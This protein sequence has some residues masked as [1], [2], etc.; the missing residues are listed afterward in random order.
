VSGRTDHTQTS[1][2]RPQGRLSRQEAGRAVSMAMCR[3]DKRRTRSVEGRST[4]FF[5]AWP[6]S[7][8]ASAPT[9]SVAG[10][11]SRSGW[12][13]CFSSLRGCGLLCSRADGCYWFGT[14]SVDRASDLARGTSAIEN[15]PPVA[16]LVDARQSGSR[17]AQRRH[18]S[19]EAREPTQ[20][21]ADSISPIVTRSVGWCWSGC[22]LACRRVGIAAH[23]RR[24][25]SRSRPGCERS[26]LIDAP[27]T[28]AR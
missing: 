24:S 8:L 5:T 15:R 17:H 4:G 14:P 13:P 12:W 18:G 22:S 16:L 9:L 1:R 26:A 11:L 23:R 21:P 6:E 2:W 27:A 19:A 25:A 10:C 3:H 7:G 20:R 28:Q